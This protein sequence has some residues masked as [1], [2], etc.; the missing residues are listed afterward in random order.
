M[1]IPIKEYL[2]ELTPTLEDIKESIL[3][4]K[5][6]NCIIHLKWFIEYSGWYDRYIRSTDNAEEVYQILHNRI[7]GV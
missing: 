1:I 4:A 2:T 6:N 7:Y 5:K 3:L